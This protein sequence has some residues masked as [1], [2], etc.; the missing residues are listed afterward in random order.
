MRPLLPSEI[1]VMRE[2]AETGLDEMQAIRR[3]QQR[4]VL[5]R[6]ARQDRRASR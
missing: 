3:I 6:K 5:I 2:M 1:A 4:R